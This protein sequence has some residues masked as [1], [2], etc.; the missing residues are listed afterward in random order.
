L[1]NALLEA[2]AAGLPIVAL[3][4]SQGLVTLLSGHPGIWLAKEISAIGLEMALCDALT[5]IQSGQLFEHAWIEAFD[6][7]KAISAH[8]DLVEAVLLER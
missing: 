5:S 1:P 6:Q 3:P 8:E 7:K 2:A 4:A